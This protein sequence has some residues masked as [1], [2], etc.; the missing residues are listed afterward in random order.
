MK[1]PAGIEEGLGELGGRDVEDAD[2]VI[3]AV[4]RGVARAQQGR[5]DLPVA[6]AGTIVAGGNV[7]GETVADLIRSGDV[8]LI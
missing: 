5:Q 8:F 1:G 6:I 4:R 3:G 7:R 2:M